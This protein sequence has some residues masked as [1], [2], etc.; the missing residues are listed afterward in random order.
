MIA[1]K[2]LRGEGGGGG[3]G[4][5][6]CRNKYMN[7]EDADAGLFEL[8]SSIEGATIADRDRTLFTAEC[9][10]I[11]SDLRTSVL[12]AG[13]RSKEASLWLPPDDLSPLVGF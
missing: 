11:S 3:G 7:E 12:T 1:I 2:I 13:L 5:K 4:L 6:C 9:G 8:F 10:R